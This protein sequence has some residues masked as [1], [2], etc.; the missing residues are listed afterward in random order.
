MVKWMNLLGNEKQHQHNRKKSHFTTISH[1]LATKMLQQT[2]LLSLLLGITSFNRGQG[3]VAAT[4]TFDEGYID[5]Y[6]KNNND[7]NAVSCIDKNYNNNNNDNNNNYY[8]NNKNDRQSNDI[9]VALDLPF[10]SIRG[11]LYAAA[12]AVAIHNINNNKELL[13]GYRLRYA[14]HINETDTGCIEKNAI[15]IMLR[16]LNM[17]VSGFLGFNC[18]CRTVSKISSAVNLPLFS[19]V[20]NCSYFQSFFPFFPNNSII[21]RRWVFFF[22]SLS[23]SL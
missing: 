7:N 10:S 4:V 13:R 8:N 12:A 1:C 3:L 2:M 23:L 17:N 14:Y 6:N 21:F 15:N 11:K 9:V 16:Q 20:R 22:L 19:I 5:L 18:H